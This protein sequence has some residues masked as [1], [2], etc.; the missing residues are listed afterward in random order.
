MPVNKN[1]I[2]DY[3]LNVCKNAYKGWEDRS[4]SQ[5]F[6]LQEQVPEANA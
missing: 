2:K 3:Y 5:V 1:L 6:A 4:V